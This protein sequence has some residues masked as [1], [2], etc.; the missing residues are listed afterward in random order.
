V[1]DVIPSRR[2]GRV[3]LTLSAALAACGVVAGAAAPPQ[4]PADPCAL[5]TTERIVAI[6][7]VHGAYDQFVTILREAKL[8]DADHHWIGEK[9]VFVQTGDM[10]DRGPD[11]RKAIDLLRQLEIEAAKAGGEVHALVGNHE[12]MRLQEV[13]RDSSKEEAGEFRGADSEKQQGRYYFTIADDARTAA[14]RANKPF[15]EKVFKQA[16]LEATPLGYVEMMKA[17][18]PDGE[19]GKWMKNHDTMI[20]INGIVF[21]HAGPSTAIAAV[22][23]TN[24]NAQVRRELQR[25]VPP[26]NDKMMIW[27]S[28]GPLWYRGLVTPDPQGTYALATPAEFDSILAKLDAKAIVVGHTVFGTATITGRRDDRLFPIDTGMLGGVNYPNGAPSALEIMGGAW[29]AI[30]EGKREVIKKGS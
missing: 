4:K 20:E 26:W 28:D 29:T 17:F 24:V 11:S 6:G 30:Y 10:M 12:A 5:E 3:L 27:R 19:Y 15:D 23:C 18:S 9:T 16:F 25:V 13:L 8:I 7:D 2:P 21:M 1:A 22:G 14:Q